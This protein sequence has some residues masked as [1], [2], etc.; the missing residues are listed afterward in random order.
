MKDRTTSWKI[1]RRREK[2]ERR[3]I[4]NVVG[5][6]RALDPSRAARPLFLV[7]YL[8]GKK[9]GLVNALYNYIRGSPDPFSSCMH[10]YKRRNKV[11]WLREPNWLASLAWP[12]PIFAQGRYHLQYKRPAKRIWSGSQAWLEP[13][14][15]YPTDTRRVYYLC[16]NWHVQKCQ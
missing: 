8:D 7:L 4:H 13:Y 5:Y 1:E 14:I 15:L 10:E 16:W 2:I 9:K 6:R 11:V 3:S 12:D